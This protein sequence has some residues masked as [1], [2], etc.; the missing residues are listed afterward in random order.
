MIRVIQA[1]SPIHLLYFMLNVRLQN[2]YLRTYIPDYSD[3]QA[4]TLQINS[5]SD[6]VF[7]EVPSG[8]EPLWE[9]LQS[10]A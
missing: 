4:L 1:R 3:E 6:A 2:F 8:F 9:L 5:Y 7:V 10:S